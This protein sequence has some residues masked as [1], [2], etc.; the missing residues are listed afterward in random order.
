MMSGEGA[1]IDNPSTA[2]MLARAIATGS[3]VS[4]RTTT[5]AVG[6]IV[7]VQLRSMTAEESEERGW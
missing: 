6:S 2:D 4:S 1:P 3:A 5:T 7:I